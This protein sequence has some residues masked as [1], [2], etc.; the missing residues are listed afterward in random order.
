MPDSSCGPWVDK[1]ILFGE[2]VAS[3]A[4]QQR[5]TKQAP[6]QEAALRRFRV[7]FAWHAWGK[8]WGLLNAPLLYPDQ[9]SVQQVRDV[10]A[11][12]VKAA[13]AAFVES[14]VA[15]VGVTEG[16]YLHILHAHAHQQ[17]AKWG[18]LRVRQSQVCVHMSV[19]YMFDRVFCI[20][21][22]NVC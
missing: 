6:N 8:C 10:R 20:L 9:E 3:L 2:Q 12:E 16:L 5:A 11:R 4:A 22:C 1:D 7:R 13:T 21:A 19:E 14:H 15:A 18:D 17:V